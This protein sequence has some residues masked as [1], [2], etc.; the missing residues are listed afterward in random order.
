MSLI[1]N[2]KDEYVNFMGIK[3]KLNNIYF[4]EDYKLA[5]RIYG[6]LQFLIEDRILYRYKIKS[7]PYHG[8]NKI[9][10]AEYPMI[11]N[12]FM[13]MKKYMEE[14]KNLNEI[15][16]KMDD[17]K[18]YFIYIINN[19]TT[20]FS[21][22]YNDNDNKITVTNEYVQYRKI[23]IILDPR[24]KFLLDKAGK[25][26][27]LRMLLRYF[28]FGLTGQHCS[29]SI[30]VYTYMYDE[31]GIRGEGFSS[32]LNSKLLTMKDTVFCTLFKDTDKYIG[33]KGPFSH[34]ILVKYSDKNWTVNPPYFP[35]VM[36]LAYHEVMKAFKK[37]K[38]PD[39]LVIVLLPKWENDIAYQKFKNCRYLVKLIEPD[40]GKHYMNCNGRTVY[41]NK[42]VNSMFFLCREKNIITETKIKKLLLLWNTFIDDKIHQSQ[43]TLPEIL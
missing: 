40:E 24:L 43:I 4:I 7:P 33:S 16:M 38:R 42:L 23:K 27:F 32:P 12:F 31:F 3:K 13:D 22:M 36:L 9:E 18:E 41:M 34:K 6:D 37:I 19:K 25:E 1:N 14:K 21:N 10:D 39:F 15:Y 5:S 11:N 17:I 30:N 2:I 8:Y 35:A 26:R 28:G 29:L 20:L